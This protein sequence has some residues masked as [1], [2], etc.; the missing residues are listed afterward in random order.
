V[1]L[2]TVSDSKETT[3][4][5]KDKDFLGHKERCA[6]SEKCRSR[7]CISLIGRKVEEP[8]TRGRCLGNWRGGKG[9]RKR[10][11]P[12]SIANP[13]GRPA[14]LREFLGGGGGER[15]LHPGGDLYLEG[16]NKAHERGRLKKRRRAWMNNPEEQH[17]RNRDVTRLVGLERGTRIAR[18]P[19]SKFCRAKKIVRQY[20]LG[21]VA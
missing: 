4:G 11:F 20:M 13:V 10:G 14:I 19:E 21:R 1:K 12:C 18:Q 8:K 6:Q 3:R 7:V 2:V 16:N 17:Y 15:V 5:E 9:R